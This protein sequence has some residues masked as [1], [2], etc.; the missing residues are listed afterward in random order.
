MQREDETVFMSLVEGVIMS[1][2][3]KD[4]TAEKHGTAQRVVESA[5]MEVIQKFL[6]GELTNFQTAIENAIKIHL[7]HCHLDEAQ[8]MPVHSDMEISSEDGEND[9]TKLERAKTMCSESSSNSTVSDAKHP[10]CRPFSKLESLRI[11]GGKEDTSSEVE[12]ECTLTKS[13]LFL[14]FDSLPKLNK[15]PEHVT[16]LEELHISH[17]NMNTFPEW[18]FSQTWR[19]WR[20][21]IVPSYCKDAKMKLVRDWEKIEHFENRL[22]QKRQS[23]LIRSSPNGALATVPTL[24]SL[25]S[26]SCKRVTHFRFNVACWSF[27]LDV[28]CFRRRNIVPTTLLWLTYLTANRIAPYAIGLISNSQSDPSKGNK[29]I[30]PFWVSFLLLHLGGPDSITSYSLEDNEPW[31]RHIFVLAAKLF[32]AGYI[33]F[34]TFPDNNLWFPTILVRLV[35][36]IKYAEKTAALYLLSL[37]RFRASTLPKP[38]PGYD[39]EKAVAKYYRA[40]SVKVVEQTEI[41]MVEKLGNSYKGRSLDDDSEKPDDMERLPTAYSLFE[42]FK[43]LPV[44]YV[45]NPS[46]QKSSRKLSLHISSAEV[47]FRLVEYELSLMYQLLHTKISMVNY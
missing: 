38:N 46:D 27:V 41:A 6:D 10:T 29:N 3:K 35:G 11:L 26:R 23:C 43:G 12:N 5:K 42:D 31:H 33:L 28:R 19:H 18:N 45:P 15:L 9:K 39:C 16:A 2:A 32:G 25:S 24:R 17:C 37:D 34:Q 4:G 44:G 21:W 13:L 47:S 7:S 8:S 40:R 36:K 1:A 14:R 20:L 30:L 22:P